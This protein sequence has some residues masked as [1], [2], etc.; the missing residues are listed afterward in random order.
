MKNERS[1]GAVVF[2][3]EKEPIFLLLHYE[4]GHW[5]FPK[6]HIEANETD[7]ET[8][9][10]EVKEETGIKDIEIIPKFKEKMQYYFKFKGELINKEVIFYLAKTQTKQ[11]KLSFEHIGFK[12]LAYDKAI[13]KLTYKNAK[14]IL[15][16][17]N[18]FLKTHKT[19]DDFS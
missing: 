7:T 8:V 2:I 16:K 9:K 17:A 10:R 4:E 1:A 6:G 5:D 13:E 15:I 18:N 11:I 12:W 14:E 19:L 3:K